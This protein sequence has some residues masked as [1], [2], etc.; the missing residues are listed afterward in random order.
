MDIPRLKA[1]NLY[2]RQHP[3]VHMLVAGYIGY[4][5]PAEASI[6]ESEE[7]ARELMQMFAAAP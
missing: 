1:M 4:K 5:A 3:P 7:Q 2:W 6:G